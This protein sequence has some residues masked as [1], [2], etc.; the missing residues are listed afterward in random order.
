MIV[1]DRRRG[2][3]QPHSTRAAPQ[4]HWPQTVGDGDDDGDGLGEDDG[5]GEAEAEAEDEADC[6]VE[7]ESDGEGETVGEYSGWTGGT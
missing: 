2:A 1:K 4:V 6:D 5:L 3:A 7:A